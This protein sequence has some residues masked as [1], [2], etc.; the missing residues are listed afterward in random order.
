MTEFGFV[1]AGFQALADSFSILGLT[2]GVQHALNHLCSIDESP[3]ALTAKALFQLGVLLLQHDALLKEY[4][5]IGKLLHPALQPIAIGAK[6]LKILIFAMKK[7][8]SLEADSAQGQVDATRLAHT[9]HE[10]RSLGAVV[11]EDAEFAAD[12]GLMAQLEALL[13]LLLVENNRMVEFT[14]HMCCVAE[15]DPTCSIL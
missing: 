11:Q 14:I 8:K 10:V 2:P 15:H 6:T 9:L 1:L 5:S 7:T 12:P 3:L 4:P 13:K